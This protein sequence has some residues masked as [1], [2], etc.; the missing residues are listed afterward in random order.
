[1]NLSPPERDEK[2]MTL[3][4]LS[5]PNHSEACACRGPPFGHDHVKISRR[6]RTTRN[7]AVWMV[8]STDSPFFSLLLQTQSFATHSTSSLA[9]SSSACCMRICSSKAIFLRFDCSFAKPNLCFS[10][11]LVM[12]RRSVKSRALQYLQH[13]QI[14][15]WLIR[16]VI[17]T[18]QE[19]N[20]WC[21]GVARDSAE[22]A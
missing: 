8:P 22:R 17:V 3:D 13:A 5:F 20:A 21:W 4:E 14:T 2:E 7:L 15:P 19:Q 9:S 18:L 10:S 16:C 12:L 11:W 6:N 1:M